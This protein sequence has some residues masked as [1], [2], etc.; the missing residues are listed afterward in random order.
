MNKKAEVPAERSGFFPCSMGVS[1]TCRGFSP[2][3]GSTA[4]A[5]MTDSRKCRITTN[6]NYDEKMKNRFVLNHIISI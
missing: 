4:S 1:V 6:K 2:P 5:E 3:A